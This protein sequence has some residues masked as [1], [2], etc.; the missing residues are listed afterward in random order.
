M[1]ERTIRTCLMPI[2]SDFLVNGLLSIIS[3]MFNLES[4]IYVW[5][6]VC[7]SKSCF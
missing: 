7:T 6:Y 3:L 5:D 1:Y 4:T 2:I